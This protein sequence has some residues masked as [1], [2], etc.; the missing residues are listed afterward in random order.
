MLP[1]PGTVVYYMGLLEL[2]DL[3]PFYHN[4]V[5]MDSQAGRLT[6]GMSLFQFRVKAY[7]QDRSLLVVRPGASSLAEKYEERIAFSKN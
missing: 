7:G 5:A 1:L 2:S 4:E 6:Q 3:R